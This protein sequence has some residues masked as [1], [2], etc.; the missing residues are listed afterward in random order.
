MTINLADIRDR[1]LIIP[2]KDF[3]K[4]HKSIDKKFD[5]LHK[6]IKELKE[7]L[8]QNTI[9]NDKLTQK[10]ANELLPFGRT[11][12]QQKRDSGAVEFSKIGN[13]IFYSRASLEKLI[14]DNKREEF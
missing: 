4:Y 14:E 2:E 6:E 5:E 1:I 12:W 9:K 3:T 11:W 8:N 7:I 13:R 10:Q